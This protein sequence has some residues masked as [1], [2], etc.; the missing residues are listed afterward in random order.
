[1]TGST[2]GIDIVR[3]FMERINAGDV[4]G[5][6]A[7]VHPEIDVQEPWSMPYGGRYS[8]HA[9]F[10]A[11]MGKIHETWRSWRETPNRFAEGDGMVFR[12]C[13]VRGRLRS[14]GQVVEMPFVEMFELRDGL[15][16]SMRPHYWDPGLLAA[17]TDGQ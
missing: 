11:L 15:I 3:A 10:Q 14:S 6:L 17:G 9:E 4:A 1:M 7:H 8:G 2:S 13:T 12:E 16:V 5:S